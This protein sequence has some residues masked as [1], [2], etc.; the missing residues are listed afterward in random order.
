MHKKLGGS[1]GEV[2]G[3]E[4]LVPFGSAAIRRAGSD[5]TIVG[6]SQIMFK[7]MEAAKALAESGIEAG[8]LSFEITE[9]AAVADLLEQAHGIRRRRRS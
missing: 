6:Y 1:R 9:T 5:V 3:D 8:R 2:G 7:A 4:D